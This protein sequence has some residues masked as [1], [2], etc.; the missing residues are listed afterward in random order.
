MKTRSVSAFLI[1][2]FM[3]ATCTKNEIL[4]NASN[5]LSSLQASQGLINQLLPSAAPK[6]EQAINIAVKLRDGVAESNSASAVGYL[7]DLIPI[8]QSIVKDDLPQIRDPNTRTQ[9]MAA[10]ALANI[11][12]SF[13]A[14]HLKSNTPTALGPNDPIRTFAAEPVW[15]LAYRK[16]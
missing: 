7:R 12:L 2:S 11:G 16:K 10:L 1:I 5:V 14:N 13:L 15:G 3:L 6:I 8:F 4:D 9:I